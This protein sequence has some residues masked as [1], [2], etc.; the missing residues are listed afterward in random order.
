MDW[1]PA[2]NAEI[3]SAGVLNSVKVV[4]PKQSGASFRRDGTEQLPQEFRIRLHLENLQCDPSDRRHDREPWEPVPDS[5]VVTILNWPSTQGGALS[6]QAGPGGVVII[7][8]NTPH[9]FSEITSDQK[10]YLV[11]RFDPHKGLP[12]GNGSSKFFR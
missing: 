2:A 12:A 1:S 6:R 3:V 7:P 5:Q 11:V 8:P 4:R 9:S 10:V